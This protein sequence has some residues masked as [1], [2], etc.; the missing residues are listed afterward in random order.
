MFGKK[1]LNNVYWHSSLT[2]SQNDDVQQHIVEAEDLAGL[3][4][5]TDYNVVKYDVKDDALSLLWY[6]NFFND[7]FPALERSYRIN[8]S[9]K[10]VEKRSYQA[11]LN[12]PILHRKELFLSQDNPHIPQFRELTATAEQL[13]LFENPIHIGF[14]QAWEN[15]IAEKGFQLVDRHFVPIGNLE[16]NGQQ[17]N[18][19]STPSATIA[20][21][22]TAL[23][24]S[25]LSAPM[26][27]LARHGFLDGALSV[28][29]YGCGKGDDIRNLTANAIPASGWD[30]H[31]AADQPKQAA[32]IVNLG[33]VINV[34]ENYQERLE[35]LLGAYNLTR[36]VLVV[37]AMLINQ[38]ALNGR[39]FNDG[40][41]TQRNTFQK[42]FTQTELKAFL[43]DTLETDAIPVA[44]GIFFIF[45][46]QEAEQRFL[47]NRQRSQRNVLRLTRRSSNPPLPKLS[48][49]E[50]KYLNFK[51]LI[52]P[53]W[54]QTL[55]LGR[56]PEK[57]EI[58]N[59]VELTQSFGTISKA[60]RFML[61]QFDEAV[62]EQAGQNRIDDL[63]TYFALQTFSKRNAYKYLETSLQKDIKAFFGDYKNAMAA[64]QSALF[65]IGKAELIASACQQA[66]EQGLGYLD[67]DEALHLHTGVVEQL[68][69]LLRIY[70]GCATVLYGDIEQT[71]LIKIHSQSGKL[72]LMRYDDFQHRPLPRLLERVKINLR[73]QTFD[74]YQYGE[75][76]QPT[77]LYL[78]SRYINEE[79]PNYAEQ[80]SFDEQLQAF[81]LFDLSGYG[82]SPDKF[83]ETLANARWEIDGFELVRSRTIPELDSYCGR[84]LTYRQLIECGKTQQT[85][86][87]ANYPKQADSYTALYDLAIN[88]LDPLIDYFGMIRLTYGFCSHELG[89][90]IKKH[91]APKLDQHAAHERNSKN[92]L[93]CPRLGAAVDFIVEDE[94][95]REVA[96]WVAE[97]TP[98]DRLYFYGDD[99][100]IHVSYGPEQKG[101]YIDLVLTDSGRQVPRK[102]K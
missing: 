99:R 100:P 3:Q 17:Q 41:I 40:V 90:H 51:H 76:Y 48:R 102:R 18:L 72:S 5:G 88:I 101:E 36:Q 85:T 8:L 34:I 24:R 54:Q 64:A 14:K 86:G 53:L 43:N 59:L 13:G 61:D 56:L 95:M 1:V 91:V 83:Q 55:A 49:N 57:T 42:Y 50:K 30:P 4:A 12:P 33:F 45:K 84:Y 65:Q 74:L 23:S 62:L 67:E 38:N 27:C 60:L 94:N 26:Q 22:L 89:K 71:D 10:R 70:I 21:H 20:R 19:V 93:I 9:T 6:P 87:L 82:P 47:L 31:Y 25:N 80:L 66:A 11:S 73:E 77:Y 98:F 46:D 2:T 92:N 16:A 44:P 96:D 68:P 69:V 32:D 7:P 78:K 29:D 37:S 15:L 97:N 58:D 79:F 75:E 81:N 63:L 52:D 35:A 39:V 28:F